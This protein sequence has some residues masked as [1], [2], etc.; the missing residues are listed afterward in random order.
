MKKKNLFLLHVSLFLLF[1]ITSYSQDDYSL[2]IEKS[3]PEYDTHRQVIYNKEELDYDIKV[4]IGFIPIS[5]INIDAAI[6]L[7]FE[8][9]FFNYGEDNNGEDIRLNRWCVDDRFIQINKIKNIYVIKNLNDIYISYIGNNRKYGEWVLADIYLNNTLFKD[10][11]ITPLAMKANKAGEEHC[12]IFTQFVNNG[13]FM[14]VIFCG[15]AIESRIVDNY[16]KYIIK[17]LDMSSSL[18]VKN[19]GRFW[20]RDK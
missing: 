7:G 16:Q 20:Q 2:I 14:N 8:F 4:N 19:P 18:G 12:Y 11:F 10:V 3:T 15:G 9:S 1:A 5:E 17:E 13:F 6:D